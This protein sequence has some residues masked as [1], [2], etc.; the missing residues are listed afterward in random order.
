M[1]NK[2]VVNNIMCGIVTKMFNGTKVMIFFLA[3]TDTMLC[4]VKLFSPSFSMVYGNLH[5]VC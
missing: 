1:F 4:D 2:P 3:C 5:P